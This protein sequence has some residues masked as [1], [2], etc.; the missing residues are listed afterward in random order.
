MSESPF[1]LR[2]ALWV[3]PSC[4]E[5]YIT[6]RLRISWHDPQ[7]L[8]FMER[9]LSLEQVYQH[10]LHFSAS[11]ELSRELHILQHYD[12]RYERGLHLQSRSI[13]ENRV[14]KTYSQMEQKYPKNI[15]NVTEVTF[16]YVENDLRCITDTETIE[17]EAQEAKSVEN[18]FYN[19]A[20]H[21]VYKSNTITWERKH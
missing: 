13:C 7:R 12:Y 20:T 3:R 17:K 16:T 18:T 10:F 1:R 6:Y 9:T 21:A 2:D 5:A 4:V 19:H 14:T 8:T 11:Y 15:E